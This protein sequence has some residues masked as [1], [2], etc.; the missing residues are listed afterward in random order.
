[1]TLGGRN[2]VRV[3]TLTP[4]ERELLERL[5]RRRFALRSHERVKRERLEY[6]LKNAKEG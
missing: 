5:N 4:E 6:R 2:W 3:K 1:M